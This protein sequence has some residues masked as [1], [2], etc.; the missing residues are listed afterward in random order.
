[1]NKKE[2][3]KGWTSGLPETRCGAGSTLS[4]TKIQRKWIPEMVA[5]YGILD[6]ADLGAGDLNWSSRTA[7][8]CAYLPY[9][10]IPR[11]HGVKKLDILT[12]ELPE[13]DCL[14]VLWVINHL[15]ADQ[16]KFA[17]S[18]ILNSKSRYL[19]ATWHPRYYNFMDAT[20]L[21]SVKISNDAELRL[22]EL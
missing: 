4:R 18:K 17:A 15:T 3:K 20:V 9:D 6:I 2:F 22:I 19:F 12:D 7:F 13:A 10:L 5:K 11:A 8:G 14:M 1:M 21:D 16:A